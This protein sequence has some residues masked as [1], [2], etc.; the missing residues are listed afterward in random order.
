M[1]DL[2]PCR[3]PDQCCSGFCLDPS[4]FPEMFDPECGCL[5]PTPVCFPAWLLEM[6]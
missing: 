3:R 5:P 6:A 2:T 1:P 4:Q